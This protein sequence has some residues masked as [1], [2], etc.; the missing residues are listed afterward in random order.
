MKAVMYHTYGPPEVLELKEVDKPAPGD[1]EVL[2]RIFSTAVNSAD[3]RLRKADPWVV[4]LFFG[5]TK[6]RK[7]ILGVAFSGEIEAVG[8]NVT[9]Y[10]VGDEVF[11]STGFHCGAYAEYTCLPEDGVF[12]LKPYNI[13]HSEASTI[14]FG[15]MTA[16]HFIRKANVG[17]GQSVLI[18]GASGAVGTAAVQLAKYFGAEVTGVCS[19]ANI[20]LVKAI[21]ADRVLD[22]TK[23]DFLKNGE[24]Y[25]VVIETVDKLPYSDC[26]K[27]L[28][29]NG[30]LILSAA[31]FAKMFRGV[32]TSI[33]GKRKVVSGVT[34]EK[35]ED[36]KFIKELIEKGQYKPVVD[37]VYPWEQIVKAHRYVEKGHKKGNVAVTIVDNHKPG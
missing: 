3:W 2:I 8:K 4:R 33:T 5:L 28:K 16:L 37:R 13:N 27:R 26:I 9:K 12:S 31:G 17:S 30:V 6:P 10:T 22:Y 24:T 1:N 7:P 21:G 14:P 18:Y 29:K 25:D 35:A 34:N 15:A 11:G 36:I 19:S 23:D 32:V 20:E